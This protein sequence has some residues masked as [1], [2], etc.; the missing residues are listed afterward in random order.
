VP[1]ARTAVA[2]AGP[3]PEHLLG[4][5][6]ERGFRAAKLREPG[7]ATMR[8]AVCAFVAAIGFAQP[9]LAQGEGAPPFWKTVQATCD[10]TAKTP[11][12]PLGQRIAQTAIDEFTGFGGHRIDSRGRLFHFG[13]TEA[14]HD[15]DDGGTE[16]TNLGHLGWWQVMKYWR[17]LFDDGPADKLEVRGYRDAS[18]ST[19][20]GHA[21][22]L[23]RTSA[24]RL[25]SLAEQVHDPEEREILRE[26]AFR[27]AIVDTS[28][29]AAFIS[30]VVR[31]SG[32]GANTFHFSNAHRSYIYDA[33]ATSAAEVAGKPDEHIYRACPLVTR[34]RIGDMICSQ[35]EPALA[36]ASDEAVRE[37]VRSE[38][39]GG[40]GVRSIRRSHCEVVAYVDKRARK[41]YTIGGNVSQAVTARKLNLRGDGK[42]SAVQKG[43]CGGAA[44]WTLPQPLAQAAGAHAPAEKCSLNDKKWF[45]LL[46]LR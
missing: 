18:T 27:V 43:H 36:E 9:A 21:A 24:A 6:V 25:L 23:L 15:E 26:A 16:R 42:V 11:A 37:R 38:L 34:P 39:E 44:H 30:Y 32:T 1:G 31:Q 14:E 28:W 12:G 8:I 17:T 20:D 10:A 3:I 2:G 5:G 7:E 19:E 22:E 41:I 13:L 45:V 4:R 40:T 29:S 33:F 46:Q 35:R